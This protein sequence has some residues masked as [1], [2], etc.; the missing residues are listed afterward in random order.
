MTGKDF[1]YLAMAR[2]W[3]SG[4]GLRV[5]IPVVAAAVSDELA[6]QFFEFANEIGSLHEEMESSATRRML[7]IAPLVRSR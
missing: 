6:A 4:A 2:D 1:V 5:F 3:L 7:G